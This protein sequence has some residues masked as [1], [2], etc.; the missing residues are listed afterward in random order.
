MQI[1]P[2][3]EKLL[4]AIVLHLSTLKPVRCKLAARPWQ[5]SRGRAGKWAD[6]RP[7]HPNFKL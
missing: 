4:F 2:R 7:A 5:S 1:L 6:Q 3:A